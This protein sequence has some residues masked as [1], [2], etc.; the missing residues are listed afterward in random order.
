VSPDKTKTS[1]YRVQVLDRA[2]AIL[3]VLGNQQGESSLAE[4][5]AA[6]NL[7][8]STV[9]RLIMVLERHGLVGKNPITGRYRLGL[10]LFEM[11]SKAI[12]ALDIREHARPFLVRVQQETQETV[13][14]AI[15]DQGEVLYVEKV[16]PHRNLR[17]AASLGGRFPA[18]STALG[19]AMLAGLPEPEVDAIL[20]THGMKAR[21]PNT[22]TSAADLKAELRTVRAQGYAIDDEE[23]EEGA[24]CV[25]AAALDH[26]GRPLVAISVSGPAFRVNKAKVSLIAKSVVEAAEELSGVL[27]HKESSTGTVGTVAS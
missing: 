24:R 19:K 21:T 25:A 17:M 5:C 14:L 16:E 10:R 20:Q 9:H 26:F 23:N 8:K 11:G 4:L 7:H 27:G 13:N 12:A 1:P 2:L 18:H 22:I 6:L 3:T 15:L